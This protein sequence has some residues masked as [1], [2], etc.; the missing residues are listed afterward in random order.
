MINLIELYI[1]YDVQRFV[2]TARPFFKIMFDEYETEKFMFTSLLIEGASKFW[3]P[4][5]LCLRKYGLTDDMIAEAFPRQYTTKDKKWPQ[6][7]CC[8]G[9]AGR[10]RRCA[11]RFSDVSL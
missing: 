2:K 9:Y 7:L 10:S 6:S 5:I 11:C 4:D 8:M 3:M 1:A